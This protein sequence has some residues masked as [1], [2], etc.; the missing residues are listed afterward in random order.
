MSG[1]SKYGKGS[2]PLRRRGREAKP[3]FVAREVNLF[4]DSLRGSGPRG[5]YPWDP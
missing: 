3:P 5:N 2:S 4:D 1:H